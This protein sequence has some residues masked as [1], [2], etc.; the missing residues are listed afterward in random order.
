MVMNKVIN[1]V[2]DHYFKFLVIILLFLLL[3]FDQDLAMIYTLIMIGDYI[4]YKSDNFISYPISRRDHKSSFIVYVESLAAL[5]LFLLVST[6]LVSTFSPQS[7]VEGGVVGG[8]QSIFQLL[9]TSTPILQGSQFLTFIGWAILVPLIET[10]FWNGR[11]LEGLS[12]YA[13]EVVGKPVSLYKYSIPLILVIFIVAALFTLFHITAKGLASIPLLITFLFSVISSVLVIRH[14]ELKGAILM[15]IV[16][17]GAAV[18]SSL[19]WF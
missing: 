19:G 15:H 6:F 13:S 12:A 5:G 14:R 2:K 11:L 7:I 9:A 18:S 1:Q 10:S 16:T 8:A 4:W 3:A 17:N